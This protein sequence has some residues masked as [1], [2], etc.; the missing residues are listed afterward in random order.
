LYLGR[1]AEA[2]EL[3]ERRGTEPHDHWDRTVAIDVAFGL[4]DAALAETLARLGWEDDPDDFLFERTKALLALGRFEEV[5]KILRREVERQ[6]GGENRIRGHRLALL[7][8]EA[9]LEPP[10]A[11]TKDPWS[12]L[13]RAGWFARKGSPQEAEEIL[14]GLPAP[15]RAIP[16]VRRLAEWAQGEVFLAKGST[17]EALERFAAAA[18]E[19]GKAESVEV[20]HLAGFL[21]ERAA[22][23]HH[24]GG[25]FPEAEAFLERLGRTSGWSLLGSGALHAAQIRSGYDEARCL[26][27]RGDRARALEAYA[28]FLRR[29]STPDPA[30]PEVEE[31]LRRYSRLSGSPW[32]PG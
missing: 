22:R 30:A 3:A 6:A 31:A 19:P 13:F 29:W 5:R 12:T 25:R 16:S 7:H 15:L 2:R 20:A 23:A 21:V 24:E 1:D 8:L 11:G 32:K 28:R 17:A 10:A 9:G 27:E 18:P 26:E 4:G 14:S